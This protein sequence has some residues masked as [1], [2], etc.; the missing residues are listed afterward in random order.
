MHVTIDRQGVWVRPAIYLGVA[1]KQFDF[2]FQNSNLNAIS[3]AHKAQQKP[4]DSPSG[5]WPSFGFQI[6]SA[7]LLQ[8]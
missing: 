3:Q 2:H 7:A 8:S 1:Q 4:S 6:F 5:V